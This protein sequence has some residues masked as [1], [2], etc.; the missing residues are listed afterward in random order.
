MDTIYKEKP[1]RGGRVMTTVLTVFAVVCCAL[2]YYLAV[3]LK[4]Y[5]AHNPQKLELYY[6]NTKRFTPDEKRNFLAAHAGLWVH[7][8]EV[9]AGGLPVKRSDLLEIKSN[10]IVWQ[11]GEWDVV[12]PGSAGPSRFIQVRTAFVVPYGS[13]NGDTLNDAYT[14][15]QVFIRS[16]DTCF[17]GWNFLDL[18]HLSKSGDSLVVNRKKYAPYTGQVTAF[19]PKGLLDLV[20]SG[21][22]PD[23]PYF[24]RSG[25]NG[26]S[27]EVELTSRVKGIRDTGTNLS[28]ANAMTMPG[29][30][31]LTTLGDL[32]KGELMHAWKAGNT[33]VRSPAAVDSLLDRYFQPLLIEEHFRGYPRALPGKVVVSFTL[34]RDGS[35]GPVKVS[36]PE[37]IDRM[38]VNELVHEIGAWRL[39]PAETPL[40]ITHTFTMP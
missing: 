29:C 11:V 20:G 22:S 1:D 21:A 6:R 10:G 36:G 5:L 14:I 27:A 30:L 40:A 18:W 26:Q 31:D 3:H 16:G 37:A 25:E 39:P 13:L 4:Q 23:N 32:F 7:S 2:I 33:V 35:P 12:M 24:K 8:S 19:F 34:N 17:G 38:L 9:D 28:S 15:H